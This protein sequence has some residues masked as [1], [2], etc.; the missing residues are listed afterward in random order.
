MEGHFLSVHMNTLSGGVFSWG[1][2]SLDTLVHFWNVPHLV[3][4][5]RVSRLQ[6]VEAA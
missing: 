4:I 2:R 1:P 5:Q 6:R 3:V